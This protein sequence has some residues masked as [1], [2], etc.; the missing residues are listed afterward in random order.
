MTS[1]IAYGDLS[2]EKCVDG[3]PF[4][5]TV[6]DPCFDTAILTEIFVD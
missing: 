4:L 6:I 1:C 3:K 2:R 5:I